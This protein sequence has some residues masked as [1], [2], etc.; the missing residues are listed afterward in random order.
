MTRILRA[1]RTSSKMSGVFRFR[2]FDLGEFIFAAAPAAV[3][4]VG[5]EEGWKKKKE[6]LVGWLV[7]WDFNIFFAQCATIQNYI[8]CIGN[9][10]KKKCIWPLNIVPSPPK[11]I[12]NLFVGQCV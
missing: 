5:E 8:C 11:Y 4:R 12:I 7:G 6:C 3:R 10:Q 2:C 9:L 1:K